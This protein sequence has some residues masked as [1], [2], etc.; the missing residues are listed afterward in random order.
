MAVAGVDTALEG[1]R[2]LGHPQ[3]VWGSPELTCSGLR[4]LLRDSSA[5]TFFKQISVSLVLYFYLLLS[6][7]ISRLPVPEGGKKVAFPALLGRR[8]AVVP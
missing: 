7:P 5:P 2:R 8:E 6:L 1:E 4:R 3:D